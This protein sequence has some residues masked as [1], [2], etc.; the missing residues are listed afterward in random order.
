LKPAQQ[1]QE[2]TM[3]GHLFVA[4]SAADD[5][6]IDIY[7]AEGQAT[8]SISRDPMDSWCKSSGI[9]PHTVECSEEYEAEMTAWAYLF[10]AQKRESLNYA[11]PPIVPSFTEIGFKKTKLP[12][13][14]FWP[15]L[16][17]WKRSVAADSLKKENYA[18]PV[19]NQ[20]SSPTFLAEL[21]ERLRQS[22]H[23]YF[24]TTL[25][26]WGGVEEDGLQLTSLYGIRKYQRNAT[27]HLHVDTCKTHVLSAIINV[28]SK[29]DEGMDWPLQIYDHDDN[30]HEI[31][32]KPQDVVLYESAKCGHARRKPLHGDYYANIFIHFRPSGKWD[33]DWFVEGLRPLE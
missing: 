7:L 5:S 23:S 33:F 16:A 3:L 28:D 32:M 27:L 20:Y 11:Q 1:R 6:F 9:E 18:G 13:D 4:T 29:V 25:A 22:L 15:I 30:L 17:F 12:G 26:E 21:P 10:W 19:L 8:Q 2:S 24:Q 31:T 14:V